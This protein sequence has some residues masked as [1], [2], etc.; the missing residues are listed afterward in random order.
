MKQ[1]AKGGDEQ[2]CF[3][4]RNIH[5]WLDR[6]RAAAKIKKKHNRRERRK[7]NQTTKKTCQEEQPPR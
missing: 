5:K 2:D 1:P 7:F 4:S 3:F 6:A